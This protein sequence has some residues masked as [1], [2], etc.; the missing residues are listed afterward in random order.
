MRLFQNFNTF[1]ALL[2]LISVSACASTPTTTA[3]SLPEPT[4]PPAAQ[5]ESTS[6]VVVDFEGDLADFDLSKFNHTAVTDNEWFPLIPGLQNIFE[7]STEE[8]G[9]TIPH[10]II[11]TV[12]D[13]TKEIFGVRT[14]VVWVQDY[15]AGVL[16]EAELSFY[17]QDADGVIWHMGEYPE[18]YENGAL[19]EAPAWI[20]GFKGAKPGIAMKANPQLGFPSYS[21]GWGPAVNWTDRGQVAE[22]G[23]EFCGP[24]YCYKDVLLIE[25][26]SKEEPDGFQLKYFARGVGNVRVGW[27]GA[28]ATRETLELVQHNQLTP[29]EIAE[30]RAAA[31]ELEANAYKVSKEVYDQTPPSE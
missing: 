11:F 23:L 18:V 26:F 12:T 22:M 29:D 17:A 5:I 4:A 14:V 15:S 6:Q 7:G 16:V 9:R 21:Q 19:V 28:D 31:L 30:V 3:I 24:A 1:I 8:A 10:Q 13:L 20:S 2:L 25:E 27:S